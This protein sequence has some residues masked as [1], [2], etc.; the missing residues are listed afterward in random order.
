MPQAES[1]TCCSQ[2]AAQEALNPFSPS[3][4][5]GEI[6]SAKELES[7]GHFA[8]DEVCTLVYKPAANRATSGHILAER[9]K[10]FRDPSV[11]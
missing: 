5:L 3:L 2:L 11:D 1:G 10:V 7:A 8:L 4:S 9:F 6:C